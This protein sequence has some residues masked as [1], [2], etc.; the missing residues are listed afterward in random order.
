MKQP[1]YVVDSF[2]DR[3]LAGNSAG[4]VLDGAG[5]ESGQMQRIA[6]ELRH[7]A[8]AFPLP[9]REPQSALHLR[10]FTP[11][12]EIPFC[13]H[14]TLAAFHV[15]VEEAKRI[16]V[17]EQGV[18]RLAMTC[19][20]GRLHAELWRVKGK[21]RVLFETPQ[22]HFETTP[23][24]AELLAVMNLVPAALDPNLAPQRSSNLFI[25]LRDVEALARARP[26]FAALRALCVE[27]K[28]GGVCLYATQ[29]AA[30]VDAAV[31]YFAPAH[32]IDEDA[33]T[34]SACGALGVLLQR[35]LPAEMPRKM[36]FVQG[37]HVGRPGRVQVEVRPESE[38]GMIRAWVGGDAT[39]VLRGELQVQ[40]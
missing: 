6:A 38:P 10:W 19:K 17:A 27:E 9:A 35:K 25:A 26:D 36:V 37:E 32:G 11:T 40:K 2:S 21:L 28:I 39:V 14:G 8:T 22:V 23:V 12:L 24:S 31:R 7:G 33:V 30:G 4:V 20:A 5:L 18:T 15:L 1:V 29:P 16:R 3:A 34:G 13:G